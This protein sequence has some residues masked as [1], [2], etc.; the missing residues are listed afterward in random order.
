M[1]DTDD[2]NYKITIL[3][4]WLHKSWGHKSWILQTQIRFKNPNE[5]FFTTTASGKLDFW[6]SFIIVYL[7][8]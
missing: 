3:I 4:L 8:A 6:T 2:Y 5:I 7:F 1:W